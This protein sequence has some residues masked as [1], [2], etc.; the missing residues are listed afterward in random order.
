MKIISI[1]ATKEDNHGSQGCLPYQTY[2][3]PTCLEINTNQT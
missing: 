1:M 2:N 3:T